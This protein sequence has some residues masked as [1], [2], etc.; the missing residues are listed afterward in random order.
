MFTNLD[1]F[2]SSYNEEVIKNFDEDH[3]SKFRDPK[4]FKMSKDFKKKAK[5]IFKMS[6]ASKKRN[7]N[8]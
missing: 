3:K 5:A 8:F 7:K 1:T 6:K 2:M 4:R